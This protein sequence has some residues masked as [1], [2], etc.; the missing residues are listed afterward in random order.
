MNIIPS[1]MQY[2]PLYLFLSLLPFYASP[3]LDYS[4]GSPVHC[5]WGTQL[6]GVCQIMETW[7]PV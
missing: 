6:V 2:F 4:V 1:A 5:S 3:I 7:I